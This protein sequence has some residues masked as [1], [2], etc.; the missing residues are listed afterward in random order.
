LPPGPKGTFK[1]W[2]I[3]LFEVLLLLQG[4]LVNKK[5]NI[6][7]NN[8]IVYALLNGVNIAVQGNL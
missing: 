2:Q 6:L 4:S 3:T 1:D 7:I 8:L 5:L